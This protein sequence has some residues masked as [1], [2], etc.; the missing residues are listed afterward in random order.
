MATIFDLVGFTTTTAGTGTITDTGPSVAEPGLRRLSSIPDGTT[1]RYGLRTSA[2]NLEAGTGVVGGSGT[3]LTRTMSAST[4]NA[5]LVLSGTVEVR[6]TALAA[7]FENGVIPR[8]AISDRST[9]PVPLFTDQAWA[10][11]TTA[12]CPAFWDGTRWNLVERPPGFST[13]T[14][15]VTLTAADSN[16]VYD[17]V[18][19][20]RA[21]TVPLN[22]PANFGGVIVFGPSTWSAVGGV[23]LVDRRATGAGY[24]L[25]ALVPRAVNS[26]ELVGVSS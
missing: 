17:T 20:S 16:L 14:G 18:S 10:W 24:S 6:V 12:G 13:P 22:L 3:T 9:T 1:V 2:G 11:S 7:D 8:L 5:L 21:F 19:T 4:T 26:F 15:P 23:T 25:V